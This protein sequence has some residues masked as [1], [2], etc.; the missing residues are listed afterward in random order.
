M[1]QE[2]GEGDPTPQAAVPPLG[3]GRTRTEREDDD[4]HPGGCRWVGKGEEA[5]EVQ[6]G[7]TEP[8]PSEYSRLQGTKGLGRRGRVSMGE[9]GG[10]T[11]TP[12]RLT[13]GLIIQKPC[14]EN[15]R[16]REGRER[17][18]ERS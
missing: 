4:R 15:E 3:R 13:S 14:R 12:P 10:W 1:G 2:G 16:K 6:V 11:D 5:L 17:E 7:V 18:K 8:R 9:E